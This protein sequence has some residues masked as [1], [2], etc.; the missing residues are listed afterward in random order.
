MHGMHTD[1]RRGVTV[2][3]PVPVDRSASHASVDSSID[4]AG[5]FGPR[6]GADRILVAQ[7]VAEPVHLLTAD[8]ALLPYSDMVRLACVR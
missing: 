4:A 1:L 6:C 2:G 5:Q 8:R 3:A 7:A